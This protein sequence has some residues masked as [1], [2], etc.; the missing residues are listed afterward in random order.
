MAVLLA[1]ALV[2]SVL[3]SSAVFY[4]GTWIW[5]AL[6]APMGGVE[7]I[8]RILRL[9]ATAWARAAG[10]LLLLGLGAL[11]GVLAHAIASHITNQIS[12]VEPKY[13]PN[14]V[15]L[16]TILLTPLLY[17]YSLAV[18]MAAWAVVEL[19]VLLALYLASLPMRVF[20]VAFGQSRRLDEAIYRL[21]YGYRPTA[22]YQ[23]EL[24]EDG[25]MFTMRTLSMVACVIGIF[26]GLGALVK[27]QEARLGWWS[28][29][30]L[31]AIDFQSGDRCAIG[32]KDAYLPLEGDW[33]SVAH[34]QGQQL[35]FTR[36]RCAED[37]DSS[38]SIHASGKRSM[39]GQ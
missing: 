38:T 13:C 28:R 14:F 39:A 5:I 18:L 23:K 3:S 25:Q 36:T 26:L 27:V 11:V 29:A 35:L 24:F 37:L 17:V 10:R 31:V 34:H 32:T 7:C 22:G 8:Q 9:T 30:A 6:L 4:T 2:A 12:H 19:S 33:I 20:A 1:T 21:V 15:V 16:A